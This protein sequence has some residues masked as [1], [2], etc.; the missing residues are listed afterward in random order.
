M[1]WFSKRK[2]LIVCHEKVVR[3]PL[4][5]EEILRV[6]S[7]HTQRVVKTLMNTKIGESE[8]SDLVH[9]A[10][11]VAKPPYRLAPSEMQELS[12][13]LQQLEDKDAVKSIRDCDWSLWFCLASQAD[14]GQVNHLECAPPFEDLYG[15]EMLDQLF[16]GQRF[17]GSCLIGPRVSAQN[18]DKKC[19]ADASLHVP[20]DEIKVDKTLRFVEELIEIMDG[21]I[22]KLKRRKIVLV[23][24][25]WNSKH[26]LK[27]TW[28]HEDQMRIK[29][30]KLRF[31]HSGG[32]LAGIHGLFSGRNC[33]LVRRI[34]CG[35]P[36]PELEG[37]RFG[38]IQER[39]RSSAWCLRDR[40]STPTQVLVEGSDG[41]VFPSPVRSLVE[42]TM[43]P[44][45]EL[46][47]YK[48]PLVEL[49]E[50][51]WGDRIGES[52]WMRVIGLDP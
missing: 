13:Q 11:L 17:E 15:R 21:E 19:L 40:M 5:G 46:K 37:K 9:G 27:F 31:E 41:Y 33:C 34:T 20:L 25:R 39:F 47:R 23:K 10:T 35:Y 43:F 12:E 1:N 30:W 7:E 8:L 45:L 52:F 38:M 42:R 29:N 2:F 6:H 44:I 50:I 18:D 26:G 32:L 4:E 16:Y 28:E 22:K 3:I 49:K 36:W 51:G 48:E 14:F 24:V